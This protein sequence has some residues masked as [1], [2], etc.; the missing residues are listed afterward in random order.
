MAKL[1]LSKGQQLVLDK[2]VNYALIGLGWNCGSEN[3]DLDASAFMLCEDGSCADS[4]DVVFYGMPKEYNGVH[5][6]GALRYGGDSLTGGSGS[7]DDEQIFVDFSKMPDYVTSIDITITIYNW[8]KKHHTFGKVKKAYC[9]I[10]STDEKWRPDGNQEL[11]FDLKEDNPNATAMLIAKLIRNGHSWSFKAVGE[12]YRETG[13]RKL[14][15]DRG[16]ECE[17][18]GDA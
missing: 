3:V 9:R 6:S 12:G 1:N 8:K 2:G 16:L 14:A 5:P 13:L 18:G 4:D 15:I 17:D 7:S 10:V 11:R